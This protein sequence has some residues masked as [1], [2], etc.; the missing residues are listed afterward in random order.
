MREDCF[1]C[2]EKNVFVMGFIERKKTCTALN[3]VLCEKKRNNGQCPFYKNRGE[4]EKDMVARHGTTDI[5]AVVAAYQKTF[6]G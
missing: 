3:D 5:D 1:A 6:G 2:T 4:W